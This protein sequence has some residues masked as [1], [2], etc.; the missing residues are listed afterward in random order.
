MVH[1]GQTHSRIHP[2][3]SSP[4]AGRK[5]HCLM[6]CGDAVDH[7]SHS[8]G[9]PG[10]GSNAIE[11]MNG[12]GVQKSFGSQRNKRTFLAIVAAF[13]H[14]ALSVVFQLQL[15]ATCVSI[16][17]SGGLG[18]FAAL[19][20]IAAIPAVFMI[21][22]GPSLIAVFSRAV[23]KKELNAQRALLRFSLG[24]STLWATVLFFVFLIVIYQEKL[25]RL[26]PGVNEHNFDRTPVVL[27]AFCGL[28]SISLGTT[29]LLQSA[30]LESHRSSIREIIAKLIS[31]ILLVVLLPRLPNYLVMAAIVAAVPFAVQV[32]NLL[33]FL[34]HN[35]SL[36]VRPV[37]ADPHL[38]S[39]LRSETLV[40][41]FVGGI[42]A[43][44]CNQ[45]PLL[46]LT[47]LGADDQISRFALLMS[48]VLGLFSVASIIISPLCAAFF[49]ALAEGSTRWVRIYMYGGAFSLILFGAFVTTAAFFFGAPVL[50][51]LVPKL[52]PP[53]KYQLAAS[54]VYL[55]AIS[56]E[57]FLYS[58]NLALGKTRVVSMLLFARSI[59]TVAI[60]AFLASTSFEVYFFC[61]AA[62]LAFAFTIIPFVVLLN[63][64]VREKLVTHT[65]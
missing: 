23:V 10:D 60:A 1:K 19:S 40:F 43:Y 27:L 61:G 12:G 2:G 11:V 17:G 4:D 6:S 50:R 5:R 24:S 20:A 38:Y 51:L 7:E 25:G 18:K 22:F 52:A 15:A 59:G 30:L 16:F 65:P 53:E 46:L 41:T 64:G 45:A 48:L 63:T 58:V 35:R 56:L 26:I 21:R 42:S 9:R 39:S 13:A 37:E 33:L 36:C 8:P 31:M 32:L 34:A 49:H 28:F 55:T 47:K 3:R 29:D 14:R 44:L 54:M 62:G 57:N